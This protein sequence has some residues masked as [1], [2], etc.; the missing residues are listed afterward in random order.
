MSISLAYIAVSE[1]KK[2]HDRTLVH[3]VFDVPSGLVA[4]Q[5]VGFTPR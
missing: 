3:I 5:I 4:G 2:G 1:E